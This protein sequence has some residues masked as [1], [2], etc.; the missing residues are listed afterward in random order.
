MESVIQV[1]R[2]W[3]F[4]LRPWPKSFTT[5]SIVRK[6][7]H[8]FDV[9]RD[10]EIWHCIQWGL[11]LMLWNCCKYWLKIV[12]WLVG[13]S[14]S[15]S[16]KSLALKTLIY[17]PRINVLESKL[18]APSSDWDSSIYTPR[19]ERSNFPKCDLLSQLNVD[20]TYN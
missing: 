18:L 20:R 3:E 13:K 4:Q 10:N 9:I 17:V 8:S 11:F 1:Q 6:I 12:V 16:V 19:K 7:R 5:Q 15:F 2:A 14:C